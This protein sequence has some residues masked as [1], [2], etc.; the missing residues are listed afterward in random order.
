MCLHGADEIKRLLDAAQK[1]P[2]HNAPL[3]P[4][5]LH[6]MITLAYCAGLRLGEIV[7][8]TLG[9]LDVE[10]GELE[11]R[12]T[13]FFKSRRLPL[14]TGVLS[15]LRTYLDARA[16]AGAP[17]V[18]EAPMWWSPLRRQGY[19]YGATEKLLIRV[20]R[21]AGLKPE[22]GRSGARVH[23]LRHNSEFGIIPSTASNDAARSEV[24]SWEGHQ[25]CSELSETLQEVHQLVAG[26]ESSQRD[27]PRSCVGKRTLLQLHVCMQVDGC[28]LR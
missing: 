21:S 22:Y 19:S 17:S 1:F 15:V 5:A 4:V 3:R 13:K 12:D 10:G 20:L 27:L 11:I 2:S 6:A 16:A 18:P 26:L 25:R 8:L 14:A 23:D 24:S 9:A 7:S 28:G